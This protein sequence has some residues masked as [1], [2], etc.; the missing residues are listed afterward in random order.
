MSIGFATSETRLGGF[1]PAMHSSDKGR[2]SQV[3]PPAELESTDAPTDGSL[4]SDLSAPSIRVINQIAR[5]SRHPSGTIMFFEGDA[6]RGVYIL[7]EGRA[8]V[9]TADSEGKTLILK[10]ASPGDVLGLNSV[11]AGTFHSATVE[12][13]LPCRFA[14]IARKDFVKLIKEHSDACFLFAQCLGRDCHSAYNVIRLMAKPVLRRLARFLF[15]CCDNGRLEAGVVRTHFV[16]THGAIAQRIGCSRET[17]SRTLSELK[18]KRIAELVGT[19]LLVHDR[20]AL[21]NLSGS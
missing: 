7:Y 13:A 21:E 15:S 9:I 17:V 4:F 18:R 3:L 10:V 6:A 20:T 11:F 14:F 16:L 2:V 5:V 12:T 1:H 19:T 8:N